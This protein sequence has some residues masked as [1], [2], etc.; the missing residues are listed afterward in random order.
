M[1]Y[2]AKGSTEFWN[3][4]QRLVK[5]GTMKGAVLDSQCIQI[6]FGFQSIP[7]C[8]AVSNLTAEME[9]GKIIRSNNIDIKC[10]MSLNFDDM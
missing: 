9:R 2:F 6:D 3:G 10:H 1:A 8:T 4:G 5:S 7:P